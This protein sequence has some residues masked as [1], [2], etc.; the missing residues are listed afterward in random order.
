KISDADANV[1]L[2]RGVLAFNEKEWPN[3]AIEFEKAWQKDP[4]SYAAAY[5]LML[6]QL[7]Q[8][9]LEGALAIMDKL[10]PLAPSPNENRFLSLLRGLLGRSG[11]S[12][13]EQT[14]LLGTISRE[15]EQR[16]LDMIVGLSQFEVVYRLLAK[17][18]SARPSSEAAFRAYIGA[19]LVQA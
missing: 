18:V 19:A 9:Q 5:N 15:E 12:S 10:V 7:C 16:L 4:T 1:L 3:A 13:A 17:L 8:G 14:Y 2:Q 11:D 6:T